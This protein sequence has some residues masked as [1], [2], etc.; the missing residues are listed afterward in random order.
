MEQTANNNPGSATAQNAFYQG[1][2]RA[3]MPEILVERYQTG[4][5]ATNAATDQAYSKALE[6]LGGASLGGGAIGHMV[7]RSQMNNN[8]NNGM[9]NGM[10]NEQ[11]QAIGQAVGARAYGSNVGIS[12]QGSGAKSEPL[13]VVVDES[14]GSTI[15]KWVKFIAV[16]AFAS[17]ITLVLFTLFIEATGMRSKIGGAQNAE[18]KP[19]LQ[20]TR[21]SDVHGCEEAKEELQELVE[22][23]KAPDSFST[24]GGKLPKGVL[25]TGPPG[26][27]KTLLARAVAGEA[28]VPFFYMSGSEFDEIYV[29]VGAKRVRE[30]FTAARG[31]SPAIIFI[32]ELDAIGGKRNEKDAAY[33]KQTLNQLLTELD[34]FDQDVGVIIIGATNFPQS[35]DKALT[36]PG[37]FDRNVVVPLPDV[38]G[39]V[40]ILKHH[41][42]NIRVDASVDATE[43]ARGSPGF[44]GAELENLVNQAAVHASK[45]KQSKVTVKDLIWAKDK[46]MMGAERRSA[47]IQPKDREMTAYH[48]GGHALVS[49]LTAGS[50][51]LYKATIMPRGQA[52]GI[53]FS[54][55]EMDKVS[56]SK[57]ELLARLDMCMGGKVAEQIVYGEENVTTGA[58][59]D[60]QNATG[61]AYYMVTSA[62]M[63][64]KLG[65]VDL[66]SD[67]DKLS[68]QTKLLIDQEVRRLVEEGKER[69]TKLLTENREALNRLAKALVEYETL[70]REEMEKVVRGETLPN[71]LKINVD[72]PVKKP[73]SK[74]TPIDELPIPGNN[75]PTPAEDG[76][77]T[78]PSYPAAS[79]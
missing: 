51:P 5:Y 28:G 31:K 3:N 43:I 50:T 61:I 35:L 25:L 24:L 22:F 57:K 54:L 11:L 72:V 79:P 29:G 49:M 26:T 30:L 52:L 32:D 33:A 45:N 42:K 36:R 59:S 68:G 55:P 7:G 4:R 16:F 38:R 15:F 17:Y 71:K 63:S 53:T 56:E 1:L 20:K 18:A 75:A 62:G 64:E 12:K 70:D 40:A 39:R 19:E 41:M 78:K 67:P 47:V 37:R 13:Y 46:I 44:S 6:S 2:L 8:M 60:I 77:A 48:E 23:L 73:E 9:N 14:M 66:R 76:G 10:S 69:A 21:F 74:P 34:G 65:N 58:S 27:G